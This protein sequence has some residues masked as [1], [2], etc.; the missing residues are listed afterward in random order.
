MIELRAS[1]PPD[2]IC[3]DCDQPIEV[4]WEHIEA[5]FGEHTAN[6]P[7]CSAVLWVG[8]YSVRTTYGSTVG[9]RVASYP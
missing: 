1:R 5:E 2:I 4:Y 6:C 9:Y 7:F 3:P 8:V